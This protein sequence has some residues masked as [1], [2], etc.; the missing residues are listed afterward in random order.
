MSYAFTTTRV[1]SFIAEVN[2]VFLSQMKVIL[3][4]S[5]VV[6]RAC[7]RARVC[8]YKYCVGEKFGRPLSSADID[9]KLF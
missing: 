2:A 5:L 6:S 9:I 4:I 7:V 3:I 8:K 1:Y